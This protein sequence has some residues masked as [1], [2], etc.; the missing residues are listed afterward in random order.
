M[1]LLIPVILFV[2]FILLAQIFTF[3][4]NF[5]PNTKPRLDCTRLSLLYVIRMLENTKTNAHCLSNFL[6]MLTLT[7]SSKW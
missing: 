3:L 4:R 2:I 1:T 7:I 5:V 6:E